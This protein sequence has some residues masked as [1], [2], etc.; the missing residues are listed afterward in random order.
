KETHPF[1]FPEPIMR[2]NGE[3]FES[4]FKLPG[5]CLRENDY[6]IGDQKCGG[7]AQYI[8]KERFLHHTSFLWDFCH[9]KMDLL[10]NPKKTPP[11]RL[12]RAHDDFLCRMKDFF[13]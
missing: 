11:N 5:F 6:V 12:G 10:Q 13:P 1:S 2:W 9:N 3:L 7:N 4:A 8:R